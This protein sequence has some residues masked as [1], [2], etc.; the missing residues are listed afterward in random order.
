MQS[1]QDEI[2]EIL[3]KAKNQEM[4]CEGELVKELKL[5]H[6]DELTFDLRSGL[7]SLM[8]SGL[9]GVKDGLVF[10]CP[11]QQLHNSNKGKTT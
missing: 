9:V 10:I 7:L 1:L 2:L 11:T 8:S 3:S 5:R 4:D 6:P